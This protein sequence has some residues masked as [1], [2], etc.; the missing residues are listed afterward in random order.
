ML[1]NVVADSNAV[2][3]LTTSQLTKLNTLITKI[4][5]FLAVL[6]QNVEK[7]FLVV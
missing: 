6:F 4:Q 2:K 3:K 1:N 7:F 5:N